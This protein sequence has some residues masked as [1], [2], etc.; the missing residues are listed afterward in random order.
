MRV[1]I[2]NDDGIESPLLHKL[3]ET[4]SGTGAE[5]IVVAPDR[6]RSGVGHGF[7]FLEPLIACEESGTSY[8]SVTVDG[9]PA[10]CVKFAI[11]HLLKE[12]LPDLV[13]SGINPTA[14]LGVA[15]VY[16]GTVAGA[17][18]GAL[19]GIPAVAFSVYDAHSHSI[20]LS[21]E[22]IANALQSGLF[23]QIAPGKLWNINFPITDDPLFKGARFTRM[24]MRMYDDGYYL[25]GGGELSSPLNG[26]RFELRGEKPAGSH[27][28]QTDDHDTENGWISIVP[29]RVDQTDNSELFRLQQELPHLG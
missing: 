28:P 5:V 20:D 21:L 6:E 1:L 24:G 2:T 14:N 13:L 9:L 16:S 15:A 22:W 4:V 3:A 27:L 8:R 17:R 10:D 19:Y 25:P 18:E 26:H 12:Q 11:T 29:L 23:K 7:T